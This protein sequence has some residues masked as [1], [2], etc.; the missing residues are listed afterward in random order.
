LYSNL[1]CVPTHRIIEN[2]NLSDFLEEVVFANRITDNKIPFILLDD[3]RGEEN[4]YRI[5]KLKKHYK[6]VKYYYFDSKK[7]IEIYNY[8]KSELPD[9]IQSKFL[10]LYPKNNVNYGN[11]MNKMFIICML[12]GA[13]FLHRRD[14]DI[15]INYHHQSNERIFPIELELKYLSKK[16]NNKIVYIVGSGYNGKYDLDV[17][18]L[19]KN[20][21]D[22][23]LLKKFYQC[24]SIPSEHYQE[25]FGC[26]KQYKQDEIEL[27]SRAYPECGNIAFYD[28]FKYLPASPTPYM[29]GTDYFTVEIVVETSL[30]LVYHNRTV[31]HKHTKCRYDNFQKI[32]NYWK[33][34]ALSV[35]SQIIYRNFYNYFTEYIKNQP[36][37]ENISNKIGKEL[38]TYFKDII[39][40]FSGLDD[41]RS[42]KFNEFISLLKESGKDSLIYKAAIE[43]KGMKDSILQHTNNS[44]TEHADLLSVWPQIIKVIKKYQY[45]KGLKKLLNSA[46]L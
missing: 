31:F 26:R 29:L 6:N 34:V 42:E 16:I 11:T 41:L 37:I 25:M 44:I 3:N 45:K 32:L 39:T 5:L 12:F 9:S 30:H 7:I 4:R 17:D 35:D 15:Q 27:N 36:D 19:I 33:G 1:Y 13:D 23:S 38:D 2:K 20:G 43:L 40:N 10:S 8:I 14:S 24:L 22:Y 28:V 21:N 18:F 46:R